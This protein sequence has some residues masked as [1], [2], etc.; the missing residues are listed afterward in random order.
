MKARNQAVIRPGIGADLFKKFDAG[1]IFRSLD[2]PGFTQL[3]KNVRQKPGR[4]VN[5]KV[6]NK[7][8]RQPTRVRVVRKTNVR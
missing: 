2:I 7:K 4:M 5:R 8:S 3:W 1:K 6:G